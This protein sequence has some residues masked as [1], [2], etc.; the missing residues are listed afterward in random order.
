MISKHVADQLFQ[1]NETTTLAVI[2]ET[3]EGE[4]ASVSAHASRLRSIALDMP[5]EA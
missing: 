2:L 4:L 3:I 5:E 1:E